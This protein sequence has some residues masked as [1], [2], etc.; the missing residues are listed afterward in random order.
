MHRCS[1]RKR[2]AWIS[3]AT[4]N[5]LERQVRAFNPWPGA[6]MDFEGALLKIHKAHVEDGS[7]VSGAEA[8]LS[9]STCGRRGEAGSS[10]WMKCSLRGK[11]P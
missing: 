4:V 11:N 6:F 10:S 3:R 8:G 9:G 2:V 1:K 7:R 5:E